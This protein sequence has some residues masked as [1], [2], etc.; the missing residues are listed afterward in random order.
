M[1]FV[2]VVV[3][4]PYGYDADAVSDETGLRCR[5]ASRTK[6][7]F[8]EEADINTLVER[9]HLTG[10]LPQNVPQILQGDFTEVVD[11]QGAMDLIIRA[12]ESFDAQPPAVR[13]R[14]DN[15][16]A[17]FLDFT[18]DPENF[19]EAARFGLVRP[20]AVTA[21]QEARRAA[22]Q[23]EVEAEAAKLLEQRSK[24]AGGG[25]SPVSS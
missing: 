5:D 15:D 24:D 2:K 7:E 18:S 22:R 20:E 4:Q 23:A 14:F 17:K 6:Q 16:P 9:F 19:D 10:E 3:R 12:R 8:K 25:P 1:A 11:F 13:S 21:R